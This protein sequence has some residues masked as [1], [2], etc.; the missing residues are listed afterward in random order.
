VL[1]YFLI[2]LLLTIAMSDNYNAQVKQNDWENS[3]V[4]GINKEKSHN[5]F[6]PF[7]TLEEA[8]EGKYENSPFHK[9]LNGNWKFNWVPKPA[10]RPIDFFRPEYDISKWE[11]IPVPGNWQ[12]YGYGIPIYVN[13]DYPFVVVDPPKIP[14]DNNP[15]GSY[16]V[17]FEVPNNWDGREVFIHFAGV[18]SAFYL[19]LNGNKIGYSQ[20]SMT[21][22]EF[23]ITP[24]LTK[25]EN[26][27]A[28]EVYRWSDGSY[29]EDQDMWRLSGIYRD[30]FL[31]STSQVHIR[32]YFVKT[33]L[34]ED[35]RDA[36]LKVDVELKNYSNYDCD[37][38]SIE[39]KL[40]GPDMEVIEA[41]M[42]IGDITINK[43]T[44]TK[45][46]LTQSIYNPKKWTAETPNLYQLVLLLRKGNGKI[47][48]TTESKIGFRE[49]EIKD[50]RL[51]VNGVPVY[52][53]GTNRHEMHPKYGQHIPLETMIKDITLMKNFN[54]NTVRTSH[55]PN[56]PYWYKLCDEYGIYVVDEANVESHGANGILPRS[57][58]KWKAAVIDRMKSM[59]Q[60]DKN[61]PSVIMWSLGNEAGMGDNFFAMRD[62]AHEVDPSR[63]VH[64]EGYNEAGDVYS[65]MYPTIESMNE[66]AK[67]GNIKPY[68]ICEYVHAMGNGCGNIQEYWDVIENNPKF[69]GACV[70]DW[71]DQGLSKTDSNGTEFFAYGG[72]YGPPETPS[73]GNFCLNGLIFPDRTYS[74]KL[75]EIKKVYQNISVEAVD[76]LNGKV[77]IRNKYCF[78]NLNKFIAK[79]ELSEDGVVIKNGEIGK[80]N[81]DPL[82]NKIVTIPYY[83]IETQPGAEYWLKIS[84]THPQNYLYA[85]E[86]HEVAWDQFKIPFKSK[87]TEFKHVIKKSPIKITES[88][89]EIKISGNKFSVIFSK[90]SGTIQSLSYSGNEFILNKEEV[91]G[92]P[93]L[94]VYRAP[95]DNDIGIKG[96]W[97]KIGLNKAELQV[98]LIKS[99][100]LDEM[101]AGVTVK[102]NHKFNNGS[103]F[104]HNCTYTVLGNGDIYA[105]NQFIPY[106]NLPSLAQMGISFVIEKEFIN[107]KWFGRGPFENY[108]DRKT[109]AAVGLYSSTVEE[110]YVPYPKPQANG[111]KQD[112][113]WAL[114]SNPQD[115]G[116]MIIK[117]SQPFSLNALHYSQNDLENAT[118]TNE[119]KQRDE[120]YLTISGFERGVGN[121]SCGPKILEQYEVKAK[122][123]AFSYILRPYDSK[124]GMPNNYA[125]SST[126]NVTSP[127]LILRDIMGF[128][129]INSILPDAE[130]YYTLDGNEP[131]K[132]SF[133][134]SKPFEQVYPATIK[135]K[136]F[137]DK[138]MSSVAITEVS[139]LKALNPIISPK[140][141]FFTDSI[142]ITLRSP[143]LSGDI[144]YTLDGSEPVETSALYHNPFNV[145]ETSTIEAKVFREG[146]IPSESIHS[147]YK[148]VKLGEGILYKYYI[149]RWGS[150]PNFMELVADK[151]GIIGQFRLNE[152][153][154]NKDHYALLL[155]TN[156]DIEESGE[157][158]FF[159]GS[160]DGSKLYV[161]NM[162]LIDND[163]SHGYHEK[164]E[165]II[166]SKG[167]HTIE[168]RYFQ[169]GGGQELKVSWEGPGFEKREISKEDLFSN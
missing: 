119:L 25:G 98:E 166:L 102:I 51:V 15:V 69:I 34:D 21:P 20:G 145:K 158:V 93:I 104:L 106:G 4:F 86:G 83:D 151:T 37:K 92:G 99:E 124:N 163:G 167:K 77:N 28:V 64:Y 23:N 89:K 88:K 116:L 62:Y 66:Y 121:E 5:S 76:L 127:P 108:S 138:K 16:R 113:R 87:S 74:A 47:I 153:E 122:P 144:R 164:A 44:D 50:S 133:K 6:I 159:S 26:V 91:N 156:I 169:K 3:E 32:D 146:L 11:E 52:L 55:Y 128:V 150:T 110:Q 154:T 80:I 73:N 84:F 57:N 120:I 131:T 63:P 115:E 125:R 14:H 139:Q 111:S 78:T 134:Y 107:I 7:A 135:A 141:A 53:K 132:R 168:V 94:N 61:H 123:T 81:I 117:R 42:N 12:M 157:Y 160:N 75:W 152:I 95:L 45:I 18:K 38:Y 161:D 13:T 58:P 40:F 143:M 101:T 129:T 97:N 35:Y 29:L 147:T 31:F 27:L 8:K 17:N 118:H 30:V 10:E 71:V 43:N 137:I 103:G 105:D 68:F 85:K 109:A 96:E 65:M 155:M 136:S 19:W 22:A 112:V 54:I 90:S 24:Y 148:Q 70:W 46:E 114:F 39:A 59:I 48:E 100:L 130:I 82:K 165:K 41:S 126:N 149:G 162:L 33:D 67:G 1:K 72:D 36:Q 140:D 2:I 9:S 142:K 79:W 56:D 60:R 49:I